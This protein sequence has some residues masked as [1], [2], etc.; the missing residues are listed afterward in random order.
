MKTTLAIKI[1]FSAMVAMALPIQSAAQDGQMLRKAANGVEVDISRTYYDPDNTVIQDKLKVIQFK[2]GFGTFEGGRNYTKAFGKQSFAHA[3]EDAEK[4]MKQALGLEKAQVLTI[5]RESNHLKHLKRFNGGIYRF[6]EGVSAE[7]KLSMEDITFAL[8][9]GIYFAVGIHETRDKTLKELGILRRGCTVAG[10]DNG[11]IGQNND[12][13]AKY[14]GA[15]VLVKSTDDKI[16]LLT[17]SSP[18]VWLMGMSENIGVVV[19]TI[20]AFFSGHSIR[21]GGLPDGAIIMDALMSYKSVDDIV[22]NY[23]D[24]K[25]AVALAVNFAD[26]NGGLAS[27]EF[28]AKQYTGNIVI[29]P[30]SGEHFIVHANHPRFSEKYLIETWFEGDKGKANRMLAR[31][32]WRQEFAENFLATSVGKKVK[33]LQQLFRTY[34]ILFAGSDGMDFRSGISVIWNVREQAAYISPDRPDITKYQRVTW[35]D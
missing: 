27:I 8:L 13:P 34:P 16:M 33:E 30:R 25:M 28:N 10:F 11:M 31:T 1:I 7:T 22:E 4:S 3:V 19:N 24:T 35:S 29:R 6:L 15:N 2:G 9:D 18:L 12:N 17:I 26:R 32:I 23:R 14:A 20:D 5:L 21:Q